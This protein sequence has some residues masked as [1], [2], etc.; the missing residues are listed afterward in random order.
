MGATKAAS[1]RALGHV[2]IGATD[3]QAWKEF[4]SDLMGLQVAE[5][6]EDR[7]LLRM[8]E[9]GYRLDIRK[10]ER[11]GVLVAGWDVGT[12]AALDE[13][14]QRLTD[15]GYA[16][17][18]GTADEAVERQVGG[19]VRFREPDDLYDIELFWGKKRATEAFASP[20]GATF[21]AGDLGVGHIAQAV[22]SAATYR[23]LYR[24][25]F[26]FRLSDHVAAHNGQ[27]ELEFLHCN[28]RHHSFAFIEVVEG[29]TPP[30]CI[31]H[32]MLEVTDLNTVGTSYDKVLDGAAPLRSTLGRHTNDRMTSWYA[33]SPSGFGVEYGVGG[34]LV[35]DETWLPTRYDDAHTWGHRRAR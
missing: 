17:T 33:M 6:S 2:V 28:P 10:S 21:V 15:E 32:L 22:T 31:A 14:A 30:V 9:Y 34:I 18:A 7:L 23:R 4:G 20:V 25:I 13:L 29:V 16:V 8:D 35:D 26:G 11:E 1:V 12:P 24:D 5:H 27:A 3:L 19:L